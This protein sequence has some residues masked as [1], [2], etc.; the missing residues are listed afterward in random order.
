MAYNYS[1]LTAD[2]MEKLP[3]DKQAEVYDFATFLE[4]KTQKHLPHRTKKSSLLD[5]VGIGRSGKSDN[6]VN[7]DKYLYERS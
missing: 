6:S 5:L 7:H 3:A 2:T 1:Q 4:A